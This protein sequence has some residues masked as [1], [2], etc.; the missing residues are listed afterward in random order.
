LLKDVSIAA[1]FKRGYT[2]AKV[3]VPGGREL[4]ACVAAAAVC[5]CLDLML[6]CSLFCWF[7]VENS[8]LKHL[9]VRDL[10]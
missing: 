3:R 8:A 10:L 2:S 6:N 7:Q 9:V 4:Q 5:L 1:A